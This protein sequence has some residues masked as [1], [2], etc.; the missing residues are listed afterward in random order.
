MRDRGEGAKKRALHCQWRR[1]KND[2][3][4][5]LPCDQCKL[6]YM[7][8]T[9]GVGIPEPC[10]SKKGF[11]HMGEALTGRYFNSRARVPVTR[12][13]P[14]VPYIRF[15]SGALP[16]ANN[17][18]LS[19]ALDRQFTFKNGEAFDYPGM[20][21]FADDFCS[22]TREQF[23]DRATLGV[24]VRKLKDLSALPSDGV[25]PD[26]ADLDRCAVRRT[27][28]VRMRHKNNITSGY[29]ETQSY[30]RRGDRV[31]D[32]CLWPKADIS[33]PF[34]CASLSRHDVLS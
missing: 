17:A 3:V 18:R 28:R 29:T 8:Q 23:G 27:V 6:Q 16:L 34:F 1:T 30:S 7:R 10:K 5:E 11:D 9:L 12:V 33:R 13:P 14:V 24:P 20:A 31:G 26:L 19:G 2:Y 15:D 21:M 4:A 32:V 22:N 25:F